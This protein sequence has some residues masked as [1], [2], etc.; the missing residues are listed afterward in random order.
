MKRAKTPK[1]MNLKILMRRVY[2]WGKLSVSLTGL[3]RVQVQWVNLLFDMET[4]STAANIPHPEV[5]LTGDSTGQMWNLC[6]W[7]PLSGAALTTFKGASSAANTLS[8]LGDELIVTAQPKKPLL[9]VWQV[10]TRFSVLAW[11]FRHCSSLGNCFGVLVQNAQWGSW[12]S[13]SLK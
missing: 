1:S 4:S 2:M 12:K 3:L 8:V 5:L 11:S 6:A 9:N 10:R 13:H 7:D